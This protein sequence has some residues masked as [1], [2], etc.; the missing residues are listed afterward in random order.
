M[1]AFG[2][3]CDS[4]EKKGCK[5]KKDRKVRINKVPLKFIYRSCPFFMGQVLAD[6]ICSH[7]ECS[8]T[9]NESNE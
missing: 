4:V 7:D 2:Y 3:G 8:T 6:K 5:L 9:Y 1:F